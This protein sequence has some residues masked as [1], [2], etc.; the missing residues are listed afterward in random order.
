MRI[1]FPIRTEPASP[2]RAG[3]VRA[4]PALPPG[5]PRLLFLVFPACSRHQ[6]AATARTPLHQEPAADASHARL[7]RPRPVSAS[8]SRRSR[9]FRRSRAPH[10][11]RGRPPCSAHPRSRPEVRPAAPGPGPRSQGPRPSQR[12]AKSAFPAATTRSAVPYLGR[13]LFRR[14]PAS[15]AKVTP[16]NFCRRS[17]P[18]GK[19]AAPLRPAEYEPHATKGDAAGVVSCCPGGAAAP[20][21]PRRARG[22][23]CASG[24]V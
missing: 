13:S 12:L 9:K 17:R 1:S 8:A 10:P 15:A 16:G 11:S 6:P 5:G 3:P 7:P 22:R 24:E 20:G 21:P 23:A 4:G 18:A 14:P 2:P 19:I